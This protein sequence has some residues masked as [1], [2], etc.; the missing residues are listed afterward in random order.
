MTDAELDAALSALTA[1]RPDPRLAD[2]VMRAIDAPPEASRGGG[3]PALAALSA[4][5]LVFLAVAIGW[6]SARPGALPG[7]PGSPGLVVAAIEPAIE[8]PHEAAVVVRRP[9]VGPP[10]ASR[11][12]APWPYGL[13]AL[14]R[15][16]PLAI[17]RIE[18]A[19]IRATFLG[20]EP[21]SI[22]QLEIESLER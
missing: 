11:D 1:V 10:R 6:W 14:E 13:P 3:W 18:R 19:P 9:A 20:V 2:R 4:T 21:L 17:E 12:E 8:P 15:A 5:A 22:A 16:E 7:A